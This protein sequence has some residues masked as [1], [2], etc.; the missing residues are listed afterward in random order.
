MRRGAAG[1]GSRRPWWDPHLVAS[2]R[3]PGVRARIGRH[4]GARRGGSG[5]GRAE[6]RNSAASQQPH[7]SSLRRRWSVAA[8][9][10]AIDGWLANP[11]RG[12]S[13]MG[14]IHHPGCMLLLP[15]RSCAVRTIAGRVAGFANARARWSAIAADDDILPSVI[16]Q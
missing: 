6:Q 7:V 11:G 5:W 3:A 15:A 12:Q 14:A 10:R 16:F 2:R 8:P 1:G 9:R 4:I 13:V